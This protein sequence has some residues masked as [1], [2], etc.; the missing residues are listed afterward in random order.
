MVGFQCCISELGKLVKWWLV[1]WTGVKEFL[2]RDSSGGDPTCVGG[3]WDFK[4]QDLRN[5]LTSPSHRFI[6]QVSERTAGV[7]E[8]EDPGTRTRARASGANRTPTTPAW[9]RGVGVCG[10][11]CGTGNRS[12]N[13]IFCLFVCL[14]PLCRP[15]S[16]LSKQTL[17]FTMLGY[18]SVSQF[19]QILMWT[20]RSLT[21]TRN[22]LACMYA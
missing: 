7:R 15:A 13:L 21:C 20:T 8:E 16:T 3:W 10:S 2:M 14:F 6:T 17:F 12:T 18:L 22:L 19:H 9:G 1:F 5:W 11:G 4:I